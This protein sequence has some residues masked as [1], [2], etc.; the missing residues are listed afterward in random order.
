M[1][2]SAISSTIEAVVGD[3]IDAIKDKQQRILELKR[4]IV[5][6]EAELREAKGCFLENG[7]SAKLGECHSGHALFALT[8][9]CGGLKK[10]SYILENQFTSMNL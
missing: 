6:L 3:L 8:P 1:R 9:R 4:E 2:C 10:F 5:A 7:R